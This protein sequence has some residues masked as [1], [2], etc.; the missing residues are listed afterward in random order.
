[1]MYLRGELTY[2][3][4]TNQGIN[5]YLNSE[6]L[7]ELK[8]AYRTSLTTSDYNASIASRAIAMEADPQPGPSVY[9]PPDAD[10]ASYSRLKNLI[11]DK[12]L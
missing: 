2:D 10:I 11:M 9:A 12:H 6:Q 7:S 8:E 4:Y 3:D 1:M 5:P